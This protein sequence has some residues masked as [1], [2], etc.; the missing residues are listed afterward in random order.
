MTQPANASPER[1]P[2]I[3]RFRVTAFVL[4]WVA[5]LLSALLGIGGGLIMVP[6]MA[7][8]LHLRQQRAVATSLAVIIPT[9]LIAAYR[10]HQEAVEK[11]APGLDLA[12]IGWLA[13]GGVFGGVLGAII[14]NLIGAKQ[15]RRV[16]GVFV[17][18]VGLVMLTRLN[19]VTGMGA[20]VPMDALRAAQMVG[21]GT[22]V[23]VLSGLL[24]V[25]GGLVMVPALAL[26]LGYDQHLAQGTS[27][28]VIIPVSLSGTLIHFLKG[29]VIWSFGFW[30]SIGS[31]LGAWLAGGWVH[32][33]P[34]GTLRIMF[35]LFMLGVGLSMLRTKRQ[36]AEGEP[37]AAGKAEREA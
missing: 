1:I 28:A 37:A 13:L 15:L 3:R 8:L 36:P 25:G 21:L 18:L 35:A 27:L 12:V 2:D 34:S 14:A 23:G 31:V 16:F 22:L 5:G 6:G 26:L 7:L 10:Y 4:G 29:N 32:N 17:I 9:A 20:R 11:G 33:I 30:L 24:G 19:Q